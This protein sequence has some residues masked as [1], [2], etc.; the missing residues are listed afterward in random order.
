MYFYRIPSTFLQSHPGGLANNL[1]DM[2]STCSEKLTNA[3]A[4]ALMSNGHGVSPC[5]IWTL[6]TRSRISL[7]VDVCVCLR[8]PC[9]R[10]GLASGVP[11]HAAFA[12]HWPSFARVDRHRNSW[13]TWD[14]A[15]GHGQKY[16]DGTLAE[17]KE[18]DQKEKEKQ[19]RDSHANASSISQHATKDHRHHTHQA[20]RSHATTPPQVQLHLTQ[21]AALSSWCSVKVNQHLQAM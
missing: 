1:A 18:K 17:D 11:R 20:V 14:E 8:I 9:T 19:K 15:W 5:S 6:Q 16:G 4:N 13:N 2:T 12:R 10:L 3:A 7:S 21:L